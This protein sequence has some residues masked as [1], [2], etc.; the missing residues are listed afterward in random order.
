LIACGSGITSTYW[1]F[2]IAG[3]GSGLSSSLLYGFIVAISPFDEYHETKALRRCVG[4][5]GTEQ[6]GFP[7]YSLGS[8]QNK[9]TPEP[10]LDKNGGLN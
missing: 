8:A 10:Q 5:N 3:G 1:K 2:S 6:H 7:E 9:R 4:W